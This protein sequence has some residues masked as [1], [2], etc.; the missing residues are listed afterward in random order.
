MDQMALLETRLSYA[1]LEPHMRKATVFVL[2]TWKEAPFERGHRERIPAAR[3]SSPRLGARKM[4]PFEWKSDATMSESHR[5]MAQSTLASKSR[6]TASSLRVGS[7][8][9]VSIAVTRCDTHSGTGA[10][11]HTIGARPK[12]WDSVA[13]RQAKSTS[14]RLQ[15]SGQ[16]VCGHGVGSWAEG[17]TFRQAL[18]NV[19]DGRTCLHGNDIALLED[20]VH[21]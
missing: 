11:R 9:F 7:G 20:A 14:I 21:E 1:P 4:E 3:C 17:A 10:F 19:Y 6:L 16:S 13:R 15:L 18:F 5:P 2:S 8:R 12:R